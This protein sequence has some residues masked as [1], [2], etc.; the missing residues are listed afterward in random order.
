MRGIS[1][2]HA[3]HSKT[4][5]A[6]AAVTDEED[7]EII[8]DT[9]TTIIPYTVNGS[10]WVTEE[11]A[12]AYLVASGYAGEAD[13]LIADAKLTA[14]Y[15]YTTDRHRYLTRRYFDGV[16]LFTT[17]DCTRSEERIKALRR[18]HRARRS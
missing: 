5:K 18:A 14:N 3:G 13:G 1:R 11:Q 8:N 6:G 7:E 2:L 17:G 4:T 10:E 15:R 9:G 16:L 12:R